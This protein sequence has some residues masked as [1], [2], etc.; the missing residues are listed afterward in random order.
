MPVKKHGESLRGGV[1]MSLET[2]VFIRLSPLEIQRA[3]AIDL[4]E[5]FSQAL[6]FIKEKIVDPCIKGPC[7]F[8]QKVTKGVGS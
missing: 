1:V 2:E 6:Q 4:D 7:K 5:D 3:M 8:P